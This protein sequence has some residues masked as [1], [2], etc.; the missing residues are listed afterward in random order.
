M[1]DITNV[2]AVAFCNGSIR[3]AADQL[4]MLYR[5]AKRILATWNGRVLG[6]IL[7]NTTDVVADGA[8]T[9][10]RPILTGALVTGIIYQLQDFVNY[11]E[12]NGFDKLYGV[13][14]VAPNP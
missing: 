11:M 13:E 1:A 8:A 4:I 5:S 2:Q 14:R 3:P 6:D 10:G 7:V 12:A 9:D